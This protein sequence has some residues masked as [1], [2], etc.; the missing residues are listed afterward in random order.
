MRHAGDIPSSTVEPQA[1]SPLAPGE[2]IA[3]PEANSLSRKPRRRS[4]SGT[5]LLWILLALAAVRGVIYALLNPYLTGPDEAEHLKY[6]AYLATGGASGELGAEGKQPVPY[7]AMLAPAYW[8]AMDYSPAVQALAVRLASVP[9]LLGQVALAWLAARKLAPARPL[10]AMVAAGFRGAAPTAGLHRIVG[11]Q[12]QPGQLHGSSP[13]LTG[14]VHA[15][16]WTAV[17]GSWDRIGGGGDRIGGGGGDTNQ[18]ADT[19][20]GGGGGATRAAPSILD[21]SGSPCLVGVTRPGASGVGGAVRGGPL[22]ELDHVA[23]S[24][25][26]T[27]RHR[28]V[29]DGCPRCWSARDGRASLPVLELLG[30][31]RGGIGAARRVV[32]A[33]GRG[34]GA[35]A[36]RVPGGARRTDYP[37]AATSRGARCRHG[38]RSWRWSRLCTRCR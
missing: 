11:Q 19:S 3:S 9:L 18:R 2:R 33:A 34:G 32:P 21:R 24:A 15:G 14:C 23:A 4:L 31:V 17:V 12:R 8:L 7:Y 20:R 26:G 10:V 1:N 37:A 16:R 22:G 30:G 27:I 5:D 36:G 29:R 38:W 6:V 25:I 28:A 35:G 13:H